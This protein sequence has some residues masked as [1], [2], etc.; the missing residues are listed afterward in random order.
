MNKISLIILTGI[1]MVAG[2][3]NASGSGGYGSYGTETKKV[4]EAY[5][6]GKALYKGRIESVGKIKFC[7]A[8]GE[9]AV[10]VKRSSLKAYSGTSFQDLGNSL[11][12][13]ENPNEHI[14]DR[15]GNQKTNS[16]VHYLNERYKLKLTRN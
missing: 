16:V 2:H 5:E 8:K 7:L 10:K 3:A 6:Y 12:N 13:C 15:L 11:V 1:L 9:Q 4:D 14:V